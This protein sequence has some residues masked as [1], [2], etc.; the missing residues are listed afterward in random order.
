[1]DV[2]KPSLRKNGAG[3]GAGGVLGGGGGSQGGW[4]QQKDGAVASAELM[5]GPQTERHLD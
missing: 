3:G 4:R 1:M 2:N 5:D